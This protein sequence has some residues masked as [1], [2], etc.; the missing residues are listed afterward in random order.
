[1]PST[2]I[3]E[4][5]PLNLLI[6]ARQQFT[7]RVLA[8][9][10]SVTAK[11][12]SRWEN[13]QTQIPLFVEPALREILRAGPERS[14]GPASFTFVDL[15]AGI[16]GMRSGFESAG[17]PCVFTSEWNLWAQKTRRE[18][19]ANE[20]LATLENHVVVILEELGIRRKPSWRLERRVF[21]PHQKVSYRRLA[22]S[23]F[24][25]GRNPDFQ[26]LRDGE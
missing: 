26:L 16:G 5:D 13:R 19:F 14:D 23:F 21:I 4:R 12:I 25:F 1:M 11:T 17:G 6:E 9:K 20:D 8:Q 2:P 22:T 18:N 10:L 3:R 7:Q 24:D 15:F